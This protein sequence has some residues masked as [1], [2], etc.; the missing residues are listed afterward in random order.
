MIVKCLKLY[1]LNTNTYKDDVSSGAL[2]VGNIYNVLE[3]YIN[4]SEILYRVISDDSGAYSF[5]ILVRAIDFEVISYNI[6]SNWK[7]YSRDLEYGISIS[8]SKWVDDDLWEYS[9]WQEYDE[10]TA[11]VIKCFNEELIIIFKTDAEYIQQMI[12][13]RPRY[14]ATEVWHQ[15]MIPLF[16]Q[17]LDKESGGNHTASR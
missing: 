7:T 13:Q 2:S 1:N 11:K 16:E 8:P 10:S 9:F 4:N 17:V 15:S 6:P 14:P 12:D 3:I 5:P